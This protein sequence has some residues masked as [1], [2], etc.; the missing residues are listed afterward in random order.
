MS[1]CS[2]CGKEN[3]DTAANCWECG[4]EL[5][6]P[7]K[8]EPAAITP[9]DLAKHKF[10]PPEALDAFFHFEAGFHR[11]DW[12]AIDNWVNA[13][14]SP[15]DTE[16]AYTDAAL[17]WVT[18]LCEDLGGDYFILQSNQT[19]LLCDQPRDR[20]HWL[21]DYT[22]QVATTIK[23]H[24]GQTAWAGAFGQKVVLLFSDE[25]DYYQ[26]L[27]YHS[28][29]GEQASSGGVCIHSGYTHIAIPWHGQLDTAANTIVHEL[30]HDC[31]SHL[32]LPLW[33]NEGIAVT[34][35]K[36]IA[37]P[38]HGLT[39]SD[40]SKLSTTMMNWRPPLMWDELAE[41][42]FGF[43]T[44]ENIQSF[45]AGTSFFIPGDSNELSYS[46]AEVFVKL[47]SERSNPAAF[48]AI[49]QTAH[50]DDAGQTAMLDILNTDLGDIAATFLGKGNWRPLRKAMVGCWNT[51][52]WNTDKDKKLQ[53]VFK[54]PAIAS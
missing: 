15:I 11:A 46:L 14:I 38:E 34:V 54:A 16:A 27:S 10:I 48:Q 43:W 51:A 45:W 6:R 3:S 19:I 29:D 42:H 13:N 44:E 28:Q 2:Y 31:L 50:H 41:R 33:L 18:K 25:D 36:A 53:Q 26:Y 47:L 32:P 24:L 20:A 12:Q 40:H 35:Q 17:A 22:G 4:T 23:N 52:G 21:L 49:L 9:P 5:P 37:P 8:S 30:T 1:A 39:Q 7:H